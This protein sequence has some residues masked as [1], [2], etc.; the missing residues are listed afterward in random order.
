MMTLIAVLYHAGCVDG[1]TAAWAIHR[2]LH[3]PHGRGVK[4]DLMPVRHGELSPATDAYY[5]VYIVDFCYP[6]AELVVLSE[7]SE[8]TVLDHHRSAMDEVITAQGHDPDFWES[9]QWFSPM[10]NIHFDPSRSGAGI[11]WDY[12]ADGEPRPDLVHY[13]EDRDLW[14]NQLRG[15]REVSAYLRTLDLNHPNALDVWDV[16]AETPIDSLIEMGT[17]CVQ[18]LDAIVRAAVEESYLCEMGG[19]TFPITNV[20]YVAGSETA[21]ALCEHWDA[22]M[23]AYY[24][25]QADGRWKYGFRSRDGSTTVHDFATQFGGGGHPS[26]SGAVCDTLEHQQVP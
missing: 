9:Y 1:F 3:D 26:A 22:P 8:V 10:L 14:N 4:V 6:Y 15:T 7:H 21:E 18:Q 12:I 23:A 20:T 17:G 25:R 5:Y 11:A 19:R 16:L 24:F 13:V 2:K